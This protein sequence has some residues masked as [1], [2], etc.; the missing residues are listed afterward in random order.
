MSTKSEQAPFERFSS[1]AK[2]LL[3]VK[4]SD[5]PKPADKSAKPVKS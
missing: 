1:L 3:A 2:R 4:K 5:L